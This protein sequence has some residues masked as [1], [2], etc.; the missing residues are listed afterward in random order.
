V[1]R[2]S[3]VESVRLLPRALQE[4]EQN[5]AF[6]RAAEGFDGRPSASMGEP[7]KQACLR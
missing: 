1:Q 3:I 5:L 4:P 2:C 6:M 7:E